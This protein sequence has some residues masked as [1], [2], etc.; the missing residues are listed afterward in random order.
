MAKPGLSLGATGASLALAASAAA[1][2]AASPGGHA[3]APVAAVR[4]LGP[5]PGATQISF[6]LSLRI[7]EPRF[8]RYLRA[9]TDPGS[10][11]YGRTLSPAA[12][13]R[14][15]GPPL[16]ALALVRRRLEA[17]G[18]TVTATYPQRTEMIARASAATVDG[19]FH[20]RLRDLVDRRLGRFYA[21]SG[22]PTI[23]APISRWVGGVVGLDSESRILPADVPAAGLSP[24]DVALAYDIEPL[25]QLGIDGRGLTIAIG[26]FQPFSDKDV[27]AYESRF[28]IGGP[29]PGQIPI[30]TGATVKGDDEADL[31]VEVVRAIAPGAQ[32]LMV[33]APSTDLGEV[34][35]L[36][37]IAGGKARIAS[38]SWGQCDTPGNGVSG[39]YRKSVET[40]LQ[41]AAAEG[42][43]FFI[44]SGDSGAYDCQR[45]DF[46]DHRLTV[47]FPADSPYAVSVG[48]TLL[49]VD[50]DGSYLGETAWDDPLENA[51][52]GGGIDTHDPRPAWQAADHAGSTA[53]RGVPDVSAAASPGSPWD[54]QIDGQRGPVSGT[55]AAAPFWA[56]SM[57]LAEQYAEPT[58]AGRTCFLAPV[59]YALAA[60]PVA[61]PAFHDVTAG[62]NRYYSA[63]PGWDYATGLGSPDV[64]NLARDLRTYV[65]AHPGC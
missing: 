64:F 32:V 45:S 34:E 3:A 41:A 2:V 62:T 63:H 5:T 31:D 6:A 49:S 23:P 18:I 8:A 59:L 58:G 15:F 16:Q 36:N 14:R 9:V 26:S 65:R 4:D 53:G 52:G 12:V 10:A 43:T 28:Q 60:G 37:L 55:S 44:A 13:G 35:M 22:T 21:P 51:G 38:L 25:R 57:L 1:I 24:T 7:A 39:A 54:T 46:G 47:D 50:E 33:E 42:T 48:G 61:Y 56:A 11:S 27:S 17:H 19:Y 20:V 40:A 29:E 30:G